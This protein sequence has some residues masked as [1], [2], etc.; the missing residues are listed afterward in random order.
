MKKYLTPNIAV[1]MLLPQDIITSSFNVASVFGG[2]TI[3]WNDLKTRA[4]IG[5]SFDDNGMG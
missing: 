3:T 5:D 4:G 1:A 2:D